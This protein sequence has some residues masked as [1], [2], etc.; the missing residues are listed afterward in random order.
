MDLLGLKTRLIGRCRERKGVQA[1]GDTHGW[2]EPNAHG[3][4]FT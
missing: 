4:D 2:S 3:Y 1:A